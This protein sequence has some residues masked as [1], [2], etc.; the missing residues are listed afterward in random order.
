[1]NTTAEQRAKWRA[2]LE[3][4]TKG[5]WR[6]EVSLKSKEVKLCGGIPRFDLTVMRFVRWGMGGAAPQFAVRD[7]RIG[8]M[9]HVQELTALAPGREHHEDWFR[10]LDHPDAKLIEEAPAAIPALLDD[11]EE[12]VEQLSLTRSSARAAKDRAEKAEAAAAGVRAARDQAVAAV[13]KERELLAAEEDRRVAAEIKGAEWMERG[14]KAEARATAMAE[15][16]EI[17]G[18]AYLVGAPHHDPGDCAAW[19]DHCHC[20][21]VNLV[22][23]HH[24]LDEAEARAE[25]AGAALAKINAIRNSIIGSQKVNWSEHVYPLVAALDE[26][27]QVGLP[28]PEARARVVTLLDRAT[29]AETE[30]DRLREALRE[31][32]DALRV[33]RAEAKNAARVR[34]KKSREW[35]PAPQRMS[36]N[37][38]LMSSL[39]PDEQRRIDEQCA[40]D[41]KPINE[42]EA[43]HRVAL[44]R[45][46]AAQEAARTAL[47][48]GGKPEEG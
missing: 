32:A 36:R 31:W 46:N 39:P 42:A 34:A 13:A 6:W 3:A 43:A 11:V 20:T 33:E 45:L 40:A 18:R 8:V 38:V 10:L 27:G 4:A 19:Y 21:V 22:H 7:G 37:A 2:L 35:G 29:A 5:P 12:L 48:Q 24:L 41:M 16:T 17:A 1:M 25:K 30:R 44:E 15:Q 23:A 28:Y 26:A 9:A 47:T 14:T